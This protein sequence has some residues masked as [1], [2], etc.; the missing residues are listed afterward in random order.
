MLVKDIIKYV[1]KKSGLMI[2]FVEDTH[3]ISFTETSIGT[4]N[5]Y[6]WN[7]EVESIDVCNSTLRINLVVT[8]LRQLLINEKFYTRIN[9]YKNYFLVAGIEFDFYEDKYPAIISIISSYPEHPIPGDEYDIEDELI[10]FLEN[11]KDLLDKPVKLVLS[12][13]FVNIFIE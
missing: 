10:T 3:A 12:E 7:K 8:T 6:L 4:I 1:K 2:V 5:D 9:V 13:E 11:I